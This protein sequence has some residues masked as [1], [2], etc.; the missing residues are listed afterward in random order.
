MF[1]PDTTLPTIVGVGALQ[2]LKEKS[3]G[4]EMLGD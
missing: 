4:K 2:Q 3:R 1:L